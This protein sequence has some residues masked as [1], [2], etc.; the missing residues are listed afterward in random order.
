MGMRP[1]GHLPQCQP[2]KNKNE[3]KKTTPGKGRGH[4]PQPG[5]NSPGHLR[6]DIYPSVHVHIRSR[7]YTH[8]HAR[9]HTYVSLGI[10]PSLGPLPP[11]GRSFF[12]AGWLAG[13]ARWPGWQC[14]LAV[15]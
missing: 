11:E 5:Q 2:A 9:T 3:K 4:A 13:G 12:F 8:V 7:T 1:Y 14:W 10:L 15:P 6:T